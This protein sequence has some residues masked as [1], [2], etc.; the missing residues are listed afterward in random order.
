MKD[1]IFIENGPMLLFSAVTFWRNAVYR[2]G[3]HRRFIRRLYYAPERRSIYNIA[4]VYR[5]ELPGK[6]KAFRGRKRPL[7]LRPGEPAVSA[8]EFPPAGSLRCLTACGW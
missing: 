1:D 5:S 7:T 8:R 4:R 3:I 2:A 6:P